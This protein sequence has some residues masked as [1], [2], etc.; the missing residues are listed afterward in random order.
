MPAGS[1]SLLIFLAMCV[2]VGEF[3]YDTFQIRR[4]SMFLCVTIGWDGRCQRKRKNGERKMMYDFRN[5]ECGRFDYC[6]HVWYVTLYTLMSWSR[7]CLYENII[8]QLAVLMLMS[9]SLGLKRD[10]QVKEARELIHKLGELPEKFEE[11]LRNTGKLIPII[12]K[13][14]KY[15]NF[16]L[17]RNVLYGTA[18][19]C[20]LKLKELT[21]KIHAECYFHENSNMVHL[22]L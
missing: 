13:Y 6:A 19:E 9:L 21:S 11:Q 20:S 12:E 17:G 7:S 2:L 1:R 15:T 16:F 10:L 8:A 18:S 3:L 14:S 4:H 22:L 5:R